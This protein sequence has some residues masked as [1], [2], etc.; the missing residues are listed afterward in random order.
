[1]LSEW[2]NYE[3]IQQGR[4]VIS[5]EEALARESA[6]EPK[7]SFADRA[8]GFNTSLVKSG[9]TVME[10]KGEWIHMRSKEET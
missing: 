1:M 7:F 6:G 8:Q 4:I 3:V 10:N 2:D 5:P 9:D